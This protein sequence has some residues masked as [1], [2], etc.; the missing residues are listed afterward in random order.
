M[1]LANNLISLKKIYLKLAK[2]LK[3]TGEGVGNDEDNGNGDGDND[4][5]TVVYDFYMPASGPDEATDERAV[6]IFGVRV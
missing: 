1:V 5:H 6:N 4:S 3:T 2:R